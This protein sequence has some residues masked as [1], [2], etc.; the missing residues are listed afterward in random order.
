MCLCAANVANGRH[1]D[2]CKGVE[3]NCKTCGSE[4]EINT[5][6]IKSTQLF[7]PNSECEE[8]LKSFWVE[9]NWTEL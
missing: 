9:K 5:V 8:W 1:L 3:M 4:L 7:C 2:W 6:K